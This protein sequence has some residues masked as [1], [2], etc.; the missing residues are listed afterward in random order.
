[1]QVIN[2]IIMTHQSLAAI[3]EFE[4]L[5]D[6]KSVVEDALKISGDDFSIHNITVQRDYCELKPIMVNKI[7]LLQIMINLIMNAKQALVES[8]Q[9]NKMITL[10]ITEP[11]KNVF[12]I[13]VTDNGIGI[14]SE[15]LKQLFQYGFTTKKTGHGFGLHSSSIAAE[16]MRGKIEIFSE[17]ENKGTTVSLLLPYQIEA[18]V[19]A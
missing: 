13:E 18:P 16:E 15:A 8:P 12:T 11:N 5:I 7:K 2:E 10:K 19:S 6:V 14:S 3:P 9:T 1:V 17:G 4:K